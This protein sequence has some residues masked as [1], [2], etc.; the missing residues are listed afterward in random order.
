MEQVL[1]QSR[2]PAAGIVACPDCGTVQRLP[3]RVGREAAECR[4]CGFPFERTAGRGSDVALACATAT[5]VLLATGLLLPAIR[6]NIE[7]AR[8]DLYAVEGA[9]AFWRDGH[10][11]LAS[12]VATFALAAPVMRAVLLV[13]V[14]GGLR[15]RK[16]NQAACFPGVRSN[17]S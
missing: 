16:S 10:V 14:L 1:D 6:S 15:A 9:L 5:L 13:T 8:V 4:R 11:L 7:G 12:L 3:A 2:R 17:S